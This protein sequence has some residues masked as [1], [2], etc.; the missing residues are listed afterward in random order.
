MLRATLTQV[1]KYTSQSMKWILQ[2]REANSI[3]FEV[4]LDVRSRDRQG[5][6]RNPKSSFDAAMEPFDHLPHGCVSSESQELT[7]EGLSRNHDWS[8]RFKT[9]GW[10]I[11]EVHD[12]L[13]R[14]CC[15]RLSLK[16]GE[17]GRKARLA[18]LDFHQ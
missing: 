6:T 11:I 4:D 5:N 15:L 3:R 8:V 2:V 9:V 13:E 12:H 10:L 18:H 17:R 1:N 14:M 16:I 7:Q